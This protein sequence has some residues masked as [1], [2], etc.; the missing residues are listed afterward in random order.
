MRNQT[1]IADLSADYI[2]TRLDSIDD[3]LREIAM[4]FKM[5]RR[6]H[7]LHAKCKE[8]VQD[9]MMNVMKAMVNNEDGKC[10]QS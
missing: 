4:F 1:T 3:S 7:E 8:D 9:A 5:L 2:E 6:E 10:G